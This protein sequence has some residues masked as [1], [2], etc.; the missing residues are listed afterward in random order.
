MSEIRRCLYKPLALAICAAAPLAQAQNTIDEIVIVG[1]SKLVEN[2]VTLEGDALRV[3]NT[4]DFLKAVPGANLNRNGPLTALPQYR[5][6]SGDRISVSVDGLPQIAGGPNAMDAPLS[7]VPGANL[8]SLS[9]SRGIASVSAGQETLGGHVAV[10]SRQGEFAESGELK[11]HFQANTLYN[12]NAS[13]VHASALG[14]LANDRHKGGFTY[15]YQNGDDQEFAD[16]DIPNT[17]FDRQRLSAFYGFR[18]DASGFELEASRTNTGDT[19]TAALPMDIIF[20]DSDSAHLEAYRRVGEWELRVGFGVQDIAHG[21]NNYEH[22]PAPTMSMGPMTM[23]MR[24][25]TYAVGEHEHAKLGLS[26]PFAQGELAIGLDYSSTFHDAEITDP[27]NLAFFLHNFNDVEKSITGLFAEWVRRE[28]PLSWELGARLNEWEADAGRVSAAGAPPMVAMNTMPLAM[29]FN[30]ADRSRD[31]SN[32]DL[33]AKV[34]YDLSSHAT[35]SAGVAQKT[36]APSYQ[37]LYLWVPLQSTGGL[38]DGR[39]YLGNLDLDSEVAHELNLGL[40]VFRNSISFSFQA[41]YREVE[42]YIQGSSSIDS[43]LAMQANMASMLMGGQPALQFANVDASLYGADLGYHGEFGG[44][45]YYRGNLSYVRGKRD[46]VSD[47][48]YRI[49]PLTHTL[50]LGARF[51]DWD[52]SVSSEL[53][54]EQDKVASFNNEQPTAG[55]GLLNFNARWQLN[56]NVQMVFGV[57]NLLDKG[58]EIHLNGYNRVAN[59]DVPPGDRLPGMGRNVRFGFSYVY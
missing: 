14:Y 29:A 8:K 54:A 56:S 21:M 27:H 16:G 33:V 50:T 1:E 31:E 17:F 12:S 51:E 34:A 38:A 52:F 42:D 3:A 40:D 26:G 6:A 10:V 18:G 47:N 22:R 44:R 57:D 28:G 49:A 41:F 13:G 23:S 39:N 25:F 43:P 58:Y 35:I 59:A 30:T 11:T 32:T 2:R 4:G 19:G 37:E 55:Y 20:I 24:R 46:D 15:T 48:L 5:G 45:F 53:A 36:R 7:A 9:A